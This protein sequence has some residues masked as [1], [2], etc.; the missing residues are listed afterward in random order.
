V[1]EDRVTLLDSCVLSSA[2]RWATCRQ[3]GGART[4]YSGRPL[5]RVRIAV[6]FATAGLTCERLYTPRNRAAS[7]SPLDSDAQPVHEQN[8]PPPLLTVVTFQGEKVRARGPP[9]PA[10]HCGQTS[11]PVDPS[12]PQ[13]SA[14]T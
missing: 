11:R 8:D 12:E 2:W 9:S 10:L 6:E 5:Q 3:T 1:A 14:P 7:H 13:T 4:F